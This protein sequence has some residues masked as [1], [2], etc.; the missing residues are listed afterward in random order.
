[1]LRKGRFQAGVELLGVVV[2][3]Y[4]L[5]AVGGVSDGGQHLALARVVEVGY[6]GL[7]AFKEHFG[8][9]VVGDVV[10]D[11]GSLVAPQIARGVKV[12][13]V[14]GEE[15]GRE[16]LLEVQR[17][18]LLPVVV[19]GGAVQQAGVDPVCGDRHAQDTFVVGHPS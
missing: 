14:E 2:Q 7:V 15:Q 17:E 3:E 10:A 18:E 8:F 9:L 11:D 13:V 4:A 5:T 12:G 19:F 1:M 6:I 16:G